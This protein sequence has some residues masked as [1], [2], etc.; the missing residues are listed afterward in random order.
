MVEPNELGYHAQM[1]NQQKE[2]RRQARKQAEQ[3]EARRASDRARYAK[4]TPEQMQSKR[5]H[6]N[7]RNALRRNTPSKYS[8]A[9]EN[10]LYNQLDVPLSLSASAPDGVISSDCPTPGVEGSPVEVEIQDMNDCQR[11]D[12]QSVTPGERQ[13]LPTHCNVA[14]AARR[15]T[16]SSVASEENPTVETQ[17]TSCVDPPTQPG[18][19][20]NGNS[21]S[22]VYFP[23]VFPMRSTLIYVNS[24]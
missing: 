23:L 11:S 14:F 17:D 13:T 19:A 21:L 7:A 22:C 5:D 12:R 20:N 2:K 18:V 6:E 16:G 8:I 4:K 24:S 10:S 9:M 3:I 15:D 1:S